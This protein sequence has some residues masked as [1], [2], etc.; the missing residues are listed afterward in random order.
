VKKVLI[1]AVTI[2]AVIALGNV[3]L[4]SAQVGNLSGQP[5]ATCPVS[6]YTCPFSGTTPYGVPGGMMGA[7]G[8][9]TGT[10]PYGVPGG[11]MGMHNAMLGANGMHE[12]VWT[13]VAQ[14]LGLTYDQ[15]TQATQNGQT[16]AQLAKAK[17]VSLD[18]LKS[19]AEDAIKNSFAALVKQGVMTQEQADWMADHMDDMPMFNFESGFGPGMMGGWQ[20]GTAPTTPNGSYGRGMMGGGRVPGGMMGRGWQAPTGPQG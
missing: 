16:I 8:T 12:Q 10:L 2:V 11:M 17:G 19:A 9:Y 1:I 6:G 4:A 3:V 5:N 14:K 18:A 7:Y 13:A 20:N 15:L